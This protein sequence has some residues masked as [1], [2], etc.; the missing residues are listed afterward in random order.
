[1]QNRRSAEIMERQWYVMRTKPHRESEAAALLSR[2]GIEVLVPWIRARRRPYA[3]PKVDP[4]FPGYIFGRLD[5]LRGD[6]RLANRTSGVLYVVGFGGQPCPLPDEVVSSIRQR[7]DCTGREVDSAF[8]HGDVVTFSSGPMCDV[9]AIF[10][11]QLS[12]SGRV[13]VLIQM[14]HRACGVETHLRQLRRTGKAASL[15]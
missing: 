13:R 14:L 1:M 9:E 6:V 15:A 3:P 8:K 7:L 2:E 11:R 10:D 4:L 12:A 5:P